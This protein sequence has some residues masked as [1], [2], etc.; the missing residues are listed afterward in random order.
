[1]LHHTQHDQLSEDTAQTKGMRR[2]EAISG[3]R[4]GSRKIWMGKSHVGPNM[5]S[6]DHH[7]FLRQFAFF[8]SHHAGHHSDRI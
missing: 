8:T 1:M 7:H 2:Y 4:N 5:N 6:G 3:K